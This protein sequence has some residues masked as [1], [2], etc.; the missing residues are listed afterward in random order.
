MAYSIFAQSWV[1]GLIRAFLTPIFRIT[2]ILA[3]NPKSADFAAK[4]TGLIIPYWVANLLADQTYLNE[5]RS[6]KQGVLRRCEIP[7]PQPSPTGGLF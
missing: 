7:R 4:K 5:R 6:R 1:T 3:W 2:D